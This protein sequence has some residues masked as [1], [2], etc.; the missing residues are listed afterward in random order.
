MN[1]AT[2]KP[3]RPTQARSAQRILR[4]L[5]TLWDA[6]ALANIGI[7][8]NRRLRRTLGR[9][10]G[11]QHRIELGPRALG[12]PKRL[13]DVVTHEGAHA[14]LAT[15][16]GAAR[17]PPHGPEWRRLMARAGYPDARAV[18]WRCRT[19]APESTPPGRRPKPDARMA[20]LYDH[21]CPVCQ[22]T[23]SRQTAREGLA[24]RRVRRSRP[25]RHASR[26]PEERQARP[27]PDDD[28]P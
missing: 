9:L 14:A 19:P 28:P 12:S 18:H 27:Q 15:A 11:R 4:G 25:E 16:R 22:S 6:P 8:A 5:G 20:T 17:Q 26:S 1:G 13:R 3:L 2:A 24:L 7:V 21:W 23:P 10:V